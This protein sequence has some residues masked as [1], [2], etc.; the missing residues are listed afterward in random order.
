MDDQW[1]EFEARLEIIRKIVGLTPQL[2]VTILENMKASSL[3]VF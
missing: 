3:N 1:I 2:G